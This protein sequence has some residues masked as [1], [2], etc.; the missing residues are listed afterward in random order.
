MQRW[1]ASRGEDQGALITLE[2]SWEDAGDA[3]VMQKM[4]M[5]CCIITF[6]S[7]TCVYALPML[8]SQGSGRILKAPGLWSQNLVSVPPIPFSSCVNS[9]ELLY[10]G[11]LLFLKRD[12]PPTS[13]DILTLG[14]KC[15]CMTQAWAVIVPHSLG[16][17]KCFRDGLWNPVTQ[18]CPEKWTV[19]EGALF[20]SMHDLEL[21]LWP[22]S[23]W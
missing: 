20:L 18:V 22:F 12:F 23:M 8:Q 5:Q 3:V 19:F 7:R 11:P 2:E 6:P 9:G 10:P 17:R 13:L 21:A 1:E 14:H 4:Q 15:R 16:Q